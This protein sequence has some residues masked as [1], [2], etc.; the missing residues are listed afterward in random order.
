[1]RRVL[2]LFALLLGV[3][4]VV[5]EDGQRKITTVEG[6]TE[7]RLANGA[8]VLL[9]PDQTRPTVTVNMTVLVG[10]RFEGYGETGMA[11]LLEHMVFKG[12]P[13]FPDVPKAIRDHGASFNGT[14]NE[15]RTNYFETM[16]AID[17]NLEFGIHLE[18]DRLVHSF[19]RGE[20]LR[21]EMTVV[22]SEFEIGENNPENVLGE[23]IQSAA[24]NWHN[25]GKSTIG[26]RSDIERVPVESLRVF[27]RKYYQPDNCV[28]IVAG[29]F[30]EAKALALVQKYL[31]SIP[32]PT[33]HLSNTYTE[34]PPQDGERTVVLRRVG[35]V[36]SVGLAYHIPAC[37]HPDWAP[38][39]VL[40]GILSQQP[41]GRLYR[42]LVAPKLASATRAM[43]GNHHDPGLFEATATAEPNKLAAV[44]ETL[45]R[46][47][48]NMKDTPFTKTEVTRVKRR[49]RLNQERMRLNSTG[50][51]MALS[52]AS[53]LGDW[54]IL[55]LQ[56]DR[57]EAVTADDV[58]RVARTYFREPSRTVGIYIPTKAS[59][60]VTIPEQP[61]IA[62]AVRNYKG[63]AVAAAG[64]TFDPTPEN[65]DARTR[66]ESV[67]GIKAALLRKRNSGQTVSLI[68]TLHYGNEESLRG[69]A[70]AAQ[71]LPALMMAGTKKHDR[72]AL[73]DAMDNL[74]VTIS[75]GV[76]GFGFGRG[77]R[78]GGGRGGSPGRLTFSIQAKHK[79]LPAAINLLG[80]ILREPA[81]ASD[82]FDT[83]KR[84][85]R[86]K[87]ERMR[88][89]PRALAPN[90]VARA[91][92]PYPPNDVRYVPTPEENI[93]RLQAVTLPQV[94]EL[95]RTQV[96]ATKGE[97]AI[98]GDFDPAAAV[99]GVRDI[100]KDW[101]SSVPVHRLTREA[102]TSL[103][104]AT[105][106]IRTPDKAN[107]VFAAGTA[108]ALQET[109]PDFP[110][111]R[112]GN[113]IFGSGTL[114]SRLGVRMR[115]KDG[116]TYGV[117]SMFTAAPLDPAATL[118][119]SAVTNPRNIDHVEKDFHEEL[120][121]FLADGPTPAELRDAKKAYLQS[122][123]IGRTRDAG[124]AAQLATNL[125]LDRTFAY[126]RN[127]NRRIAALTPEQVRAAFRK[128]IDPKR[129]VI[130]R[131]G[132]F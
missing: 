129:I 108:F 7:Y 35:K 11:H 44:R 85:S 1:M 26:N 125:E 80:E 128:H 122:Q 19:V 36:G 20:D 58:N 22:R 116:L 115:Q 75:S 23:R 92:S 90:R 83:L 37:N 76:G 33:R 29:K 107:A 51:A 81:F 8:R 42:A 18:S 70:A 118:T 82:E 4:A 46:T 3:S 106:N 68:L 49:Y 10:S 65:I 72:Q 50:M 69:Q 63:R 56:R 15:D 45:I 12:T 97:L 87:A 31:G 73:R 59:E 79:S 47:V 126:T 127:L 64:E 16:P 28:L 91:L 101:K 48:E 112:L 55:F 54:R 119:V 34:E 52:S 24:Y 98:V 110:A 96:G 111:L 53:A 74:G 38:L 99:T 103:T 102:P 77:R 6:V 43:A 109:D 78:G 30:N 67:R 62:S 41:D 93:K 13:T 123:K 39:S 104:A 105:D 132:D 61:S 100:L 120:A 40:A 14:T 88:T 130:V 86:A 9:Y 95:Y 32:K 84:R 89:E 121:A 27:Y 66:Y 124:L 131:A 5:A 117:S 25:Y 21:S 2:P 60:R 71:I 94:M 57:I 114:S 113:Y 17:E